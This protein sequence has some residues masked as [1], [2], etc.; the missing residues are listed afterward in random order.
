MNRELLRAAGPSDERGIR[1]YL[2]KPVLPVPVLRIDDNA[3]FAEG[4]N[5]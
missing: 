4:M 1:R 5:G 3:F 2:S